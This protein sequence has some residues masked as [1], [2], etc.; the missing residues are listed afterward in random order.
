MEASEKVTI[1]TWVWTIPILFGLLGG[2][3]SWVILRKREHS[4]WLIT[5]GLI[6]SILS[7]ILFQVIY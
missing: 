7:N 3:V 4:G 6:T 5:I 2:I 1:P